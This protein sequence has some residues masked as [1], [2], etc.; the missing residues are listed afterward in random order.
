MEMNQTSL[1]A[2]RAAEG[3]S[4]TL[5]A[6]QRHLVQG[7]LQQYDC[8]NLSTEHAKKIVL[9][10]QQQSIPPGRELAQLIS[11]SGFDAAKLSHLA[12]I[13][14][15][16]LGAIDALQVQTSFSKGGSLINRLE[17]LIN[18][19]E[20]PDISEQQSEQAFSQVRGLFHHSKTHGL[21]DTQA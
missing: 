1:L 10:F 20:R 8:N 11:L 4:T 5:S 6:Q 3:F 7:T 2:S 13:G 15:R 14:Q 21:S 12:G 9:L 16:S 17:Q 19:L 18:Y